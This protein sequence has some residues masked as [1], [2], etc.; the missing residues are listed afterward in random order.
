MKAKMIPVTDWG[1]KLFRPVPCRRTLIDYAQKANP[2]AVK[3]MGRWRI[4]ENAKMPDH[5]LSNDSVVND[6]LNGR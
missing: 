5:E 6:L 3:V 4:M 2:P 1:A